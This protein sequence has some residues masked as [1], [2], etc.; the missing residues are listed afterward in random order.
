MISLFDLE[1]GT[2]SLPK[3][4][5]FLNQEGLSNSYDIDQAFGKYIARENYTVKQMYKEIYDN[6]SKLSQIEKIL[7]NIEE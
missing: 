1:T 3:L 2:I 5:R 4:I 7:Y 6:L